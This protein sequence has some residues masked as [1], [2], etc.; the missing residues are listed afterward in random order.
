[1]QWR[2]DN[3]N[4]TLYAVSMTADSIGPLPNLLS[5]TQ[6][7]Y[8]ELHARLFDALVPVEG[9][10]H[11]PSL[12]RYQ[13]NLPGL[14]VLSRPPRR[15]DWIRTQIGSS[16]DGDAKLDAAAVQG[17]RQLL[18]RKDR[19]AT[20]IGRAERSGVLVPVPR[21]AF[22]DARAA[23][24]ELGSHIE[25]VRNGSQIEEQFQR[26]EEAFSKTEGLPGIARMIE[27]F[28]TT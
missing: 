16:V 20:A 5:A 26:A 23:M 15:P 6:S 18:L 24:D 3:A 27:T 28:N 19:L 11:I 4:A 13:P 17:F 2:L 7:V 21:Y 1:M 10:G 8:N 14:L 25:H 9:S 22:T 12:E